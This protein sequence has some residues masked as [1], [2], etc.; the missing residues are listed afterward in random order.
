MKSLMIPMQTFRGSLT[1]LAPFVLLAT[2]FTA[3]PSPTAM[4]QVAPPMG[5]TQSFAVLGGSTVT[6]TGP[7]V[8]TGDLGVSP[9]SAVTGF[10]PGTVAGGTIHAADAIALQAK[11]DTT[12]AYNNLAGQ[13]S[14]GSLTGQDLGGLTLVPGVYSFS[15][16]A[17]LTGALTLDAQ[18]SSAAV[19]VFQI[20]STLT[21]ASGSSVVLINGASPCNVFWQVG[22]SATIGTTTTFVGN[23]FALTSISLTTGATVAGRALARNGAVTMDSNQVSISACGGTTGTTVPPTLNKTFSPATINAGG[24]STLTITLNNANNAPAALNAPF[25]DTLPSG[26]LVSGGGSNTCGGA[27]TASAGSSAVTL[28]G[29]S[30]PV[31]S[32]CVLTV[33]VVAASGGNYINSLAVGALLTSNGANSAPAVATLTVNSPSVVTPTLGKAFSPATIAAGGI[34]T[35]TITLSNASTTAATLNAPLTDTL[36]SGVVVSG[37][38]STTCAGGTASTGAATVASQDRT[39]FRPRWFGGNGGSHVTLTGGTIPAGS[40]CTV[41]VSVTAPVAGSYFNSLLAGALQTNGGANAAPAVATLTVNSPSVVTPTLGKTFSPATIAA[42]GTSVL[43]ITLNNANNT[44][45]TLTAPLT[46]TLPSGVVVSGSASTTCGGTASTGAATVAS[47]DRTLFR[48]RWLGGSGASSVTL[49]GGTIPANG[50]CVLTVGVVAANGGSYINSLAAGA[51][52]TSNGANAAPAV[53]TL[54]V[55]APSPVNLGKAFNQAAINEGGVSVLTISLS[56]FGA[57]PA[58]LTAPLTDM[59]PTGMTVSGGASSTCGG[60]TSTGPSSVTLTGGTI[61]A[62]SSCT[63]TVSVTALVAGSYFNSLPAGALQTD[64][65]NNAAPA[66]ATLTVNSTTTTD[67]SLVMVTP[68][69]VQITRGVPATVAVGIVTSPSNMPLPVDVTFGCAVPP[70]LSG[71][72]CSLSPARI[73]AGSPSGSSTT[74]TINTIRSATTSHFLPSGPGAPLPWYL[75][76]ISAATLLALTGLLG[77]A[78]NSPSRRLLPYYLTGALLVVAAGGLAG[79]AGSTAGTAS[80]SAGASGST[81]VTGAPAGPSI[82]TVTSTAGG[83]MKTVS[84][85]INVN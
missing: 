44:A 49:T 17:Q 45:A 7:T 18:G 55:T 51:L 71:T 79:C 4:A 66:V 24:T 41:T 33:D 65:G 13:P 28:T 16:S 12:I 81:S 68:G 27:L 19:W 64:K 69:T 50:S 76:W 52:M 60:A 8:I 40:S 59:L 70:G 62:G 15:S 53:A 54:T 39:L 22:S 74:L 25:T 56:N 63:V 10:P 6:N 21:T 46:D 67:F 80:L 9:G 32:S 20:G 72:T 5:T 37:S 75:P 31:N 47:Q 82:I 14:T 26:L 38:A 36:P 48:P 11:S 57:T 84:I 1:R 73:A 35:L 3:A 29:G 58:L 77:F 42:G 85:P 83:L 61:P 34:S 30:I 2:F 78:R 23:I 43:T